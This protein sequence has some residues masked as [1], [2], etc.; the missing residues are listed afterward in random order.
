MNYKLSVGE[1]LLFIFFGGCIMIAG[2]S[3]SSGKGKLIPSNAVAGSRTIN[4]QPQ[5]AKSSR[6]EPVLRE[7]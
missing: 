5:A 3:C 4:V 1:W 6:P 2:Y 7:R